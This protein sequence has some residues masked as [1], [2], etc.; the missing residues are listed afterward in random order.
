MTDT[1]FTQ[2]DLESLGEKLSNLDLP[3][4]E[5]TLLSVLITLGGASMRDMFEQEGLDLSEGGAYIVS[6]SE[7]CDLESGLA[8]AWTPGIA[9]SEPPWGIHGYVPPVDYDVGQFE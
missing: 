5:S 7:S 9:G 3:D 4:V 8:N 6:Q 2:A 1:R